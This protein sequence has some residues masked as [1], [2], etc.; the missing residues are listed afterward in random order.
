MTKSKA[1]KQR[2]ERDTPL[3]ERQI[4]FIA[5]Y[6]RT[7]NGAQSAVAAG[8]SDKT[9]AAQARR[10][11]KNPL[12]AKRMR[13]L[14]NSFVSSKVADTREILEFLTSAMRGEVLEPMQVNYTLQMV[15]PP[16]K[17]RV[18]A[19]KEILKRYPTD[20]MS[21]A[22]IRKILAD[23]RLSEAKAKQLE[24]GGHDVDDSLSAVLSKIKSAD[25]KTTK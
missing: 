13:E 15:K 18:S 11:L 7:G 2:K 3:S 10:L 5:E 14:T 22:Q 8:Y 9:P 4:R 16:V 19:A 24:E 25:E 1:K 23:A 12:I 21:K 6:M 20:D 17:T